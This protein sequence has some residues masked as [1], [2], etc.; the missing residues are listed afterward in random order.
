MDTF[1]FTQ[2]EWQ[3]IEDVC[4]SMVDA[5][6]VDDSVLEASLYAELMV[7]LQEL[8]ERYGEHPVLLETAGDFSGDSLMQIEL[9]RRA[10]QLA[11]D[12]NI[13]TLS[14][15]L[16]LAGVF[17]RDFNDR[18]QAVRELLACQPELDQEAD[19]SQAKEWSELMS[20]CS[21]P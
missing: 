18:P 7:R 3:R 9:Y 12:N 17:L 16:S 19:S 2:S 13:T 4:R 1:P 11:T 10:I 14:I 15:R 6:L 21:L 8:R 5:I 20:Q